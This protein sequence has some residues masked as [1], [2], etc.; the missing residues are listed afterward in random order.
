MSLHV[1]LCLCNPA[2]IF[3]KND[4]TKFHNRRAIGAAPSDL[5]FVEDHQA[6]MGS[7][8]VGESNVLSFYVGILKTKSVCCF[9]YWKNTCSESWGREQKFWS[10]VFIAYCSIHP[11]SSISNEFQRW[12]LTA[13]TLLKNSI[14]NSQVYSLIVHLQIVYP[15]SWLKKCLK[16]H[17]NLLS[18]NCFQRS[19][20]RLQLC[21]KGTSSK[22]SPQ[23]NCISLQQS[24]SQD[25][26]W[27]L[28]PKQ[29]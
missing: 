16:Y 22:A 8:P 27:N 3:D 18:F 9:V 29:R 19:L 6:S 20:A 25:K 2:N 14:K 7:L 1:N 15:L 24:C 11:D 28:W 21:S 23:V 13:A 4:S 5:C 12:Y 26:D 10:V 17:T